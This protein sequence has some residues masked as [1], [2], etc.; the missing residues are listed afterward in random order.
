MYGPLI[1]G[2]GST[3]E[4]FIP[5]VL[6]NKYVLYTFICVSVCVHVYKVPHFV[7]GVNFSG[8]YKQSENCIV[9]SYW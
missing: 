1:N 8:W 3:R 6:Q 2:C 9:K 7:T 5:R 4:L